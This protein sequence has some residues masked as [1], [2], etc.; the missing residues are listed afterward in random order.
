MKARR[1]AL[2]EELDAIAQRLARAK[3]M[4]EKGLAS[5]DVVA[6]AQSVYHHIS[7]ELKTAE[8][9]MTYKAA[10]AAID[11]QE[12]EHARAYQRAQDEYVNSWP[13]RSLRQSGLARSGVR[14]PHPSSSSRRP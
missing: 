8:A 11:L 9:Q 14:R 7:R 6:E 2:A 12:A 13:R 4:F 3:A 10:V 1:D 5:P